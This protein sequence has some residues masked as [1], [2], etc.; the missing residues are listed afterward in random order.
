MM[1]P[2]ATDLFR[3]S[4]AC[5]Y[6]VRGLVNLSSRDHTLGLSCRT[7]KAGPQGWDSNPTGPFRFCK[8]QIPQCR[9]YRECQGCR[10]ALP[11][12]AR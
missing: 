5:S 3:R 10:G 1:D 2:R 4:P 6:T 12:I 9:H 7:L 11:A 8:L